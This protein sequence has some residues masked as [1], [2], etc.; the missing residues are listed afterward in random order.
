MQSH[1]LKCG[2]CIKRAKW[3]HSAPLCS[4][5][6]H[7]CTFPCHCLIDLA[8]RNVAQNQVHLSSVGYWTKSSNSAIKCRVLDEIVKDDHFVALAV[9]NTKLAEVTCL[10][11]QITVVTHSKPAKG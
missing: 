10:V 3:H 6:C 9:I 5:D 1:M 8:I 2:W 11:N 7:S 4:Q